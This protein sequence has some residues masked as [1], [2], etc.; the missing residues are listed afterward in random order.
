MGHVDDEGTVCLTFGA[1]SR[2]FAIL[3][4]GTLLPVF[5]AYLENRIISPYS[6]PRMIDFP[7]GTMIILENEAGG[8]VAVNSLAK[9]EMKY[10]FFWSRNDVQDQFFWDNVDEILFYIYADSQNNLY[11]SYLMNI[12]NNPIIW[13]GYRN[14]GDA[15]YSGGLDANLPI[16]PPPLTA[17]AYPNPARKGEIRFR[18]QA[19]R[20]DIN[21]KNFDAAGN[22]INHKTVESNNLDF[23]DVRINTSNL[24]SGVYFAIIE[25]DNNIKKIPFA[26]EN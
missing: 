19:A 7:E 13:N 14:N 2:A 20:D 8:F 15:I 23:Q 3:P 6:Y 17:Y 22:L 26:V 9:M 18:I 16:T 21:I 10:S 5:P 24:A 4:V 25:V 12:Q 11:S 1:G